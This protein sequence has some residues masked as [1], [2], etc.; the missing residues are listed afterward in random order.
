MTT[1]T[2]QCSRCG[3]HKEESEFSMASG[4]NYRRSTCRECERELVRVRKELRAVVMKPQKNHTC[5]ICERN[6]EQAKGCGG[7]KASPWA[8]DHCH[9][10]GRFRG[11]I[12]HSCNRM[13]GQMKD[14]HKVLENVK[15][16]LRKED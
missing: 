16:Y 10:S 14:S 4:G 1:E 13:L 11:W 7:K 15:S 8:L 5:P 3:E 2:K 12:C 9:E 6:A